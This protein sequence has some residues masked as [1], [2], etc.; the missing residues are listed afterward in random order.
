MLSFASKRNKVIAV[1]VALLVLSGAG[2]Y[3][4]KF[5][6]EKEIELQIAKAGEEEIELGIPFDLEMRLVNHRTRALREARVTVYLPDNL[7]LVD[8]PEDRTVTREIGDI[9]A[10]RMYRESIKVVAAPAEGDL[11]LRYDLRATLFYSPSGISATFE[12]RIETELA[13]KR[14][15]FELRLEA[16]ESVYRG[17]EFESTVILKRGEDLESLEDWN[18]YLDYPRGFTLVETDQ[19]PDIGDNGW[20]LDEFER[21]D[22]LVI[23][24]KADLED[25]SVFTLTGRVGM[26]LFGEEHTLLK[27]EKLV[28]LNTSPLSLNLELENPRE[29]VGR[30]EEL[31]YLVTFRNN[32]DTTLKDVVVRA[33]L[34]GEMFDF[35]TLVS[36]ARFIRGTNTLVWDSS[37]FSELE[38]FS[39]NET[40][41][42]GFLIKTKENYSIIKLSDKNFSLRVK[43][44]I[45]SPTVPYPVAISKTVN[46][47]TLETKIR[48][49]IRVE[50]LAYFRD[51]GTFIINQGP[52]PPKVG[53]P[54][55]FTIHWQ[56]TNFTTDLTGVEVRARLE[57]G[58]SF[59]GKVKSNVESL[60]EFDE[61]SGEV[62]WRPGNISATLGV[63]GEKPE[64]VFQVEAIPRSNRIGQYL[65]LIGETRVSARD[66]WTGEEIR[67]TAEPVN[68]RLPADSTVKEGDGTV[69][70]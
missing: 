42:F 32:T 36:D 34:T 38:E 39:P 50:A 49:E 57:E 65:P 10:S 51:A 46:S 12:K 70:P 37:R 52:L 43:A 11:D 68:T 59:T 47:K 1:I 6:T 67:A 23:R 55:D 58:V 69:I 22:R 41:Q 40:G 30:G 15:E 33:S 62:I 8:A 56:L 66:E 54:T 3:V 13:V 2:F 17:E 60:P 27:S 21:E 25:G 16:P 24:G 31:K 44:E 48:G 28:S 14:P 35:N 19:A 4:Y 29:S 5:S 7:Y 63:L 20:S 61:K 45:E 9:G 53:A 18:F 64:A 26:N